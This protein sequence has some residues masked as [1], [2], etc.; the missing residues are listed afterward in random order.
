MINF[1]LNLKI[2]Y[3]FLFLNLPGYSEIK[4]LNN[5]QIIG[6]KNFLHGYDTINQDGSYNAVIEIPAG[7][8]EKWEISKDGKILELE[9]KNGQPRIVDYISYPFNYGFL[10]RTLLP[11][12]EGGDGDALDIIVLSQKE[13][14]KASVVSVKI[15]GMLQI[16]DQGEQDNKVISVLNNSRFSKLSNINELEENY[17]G[18][19]D[20]IQSWFSNYKGTKI[21]LERIADRKE[22]IQFIMNSK[23]LYD[24]N[25]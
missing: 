10:P 19:I 23:K 25:N 14:T 8:N 20:I 15:I 1:I 18:I 7:T 12:S 13:L 4:Y 17:P 5:Y 21:N 11:L 3:F 9:I 6:T 16:K 24:K 2:I 22:T